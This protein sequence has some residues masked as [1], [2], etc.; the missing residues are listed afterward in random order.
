MIPYF[1]YRPALAEMRAELDD[2]FAR[3]LDSGRLILGAEVESFESE[4]GEFIG[5]PHA[6]G[7]GSGTDALILALRALGVGSGHEVITVANAGAPPVAAI[8]AVGARPRFVDVRP[9]TLL[10][11]CS[12]VDNAITDATRALLPVHLYGQAVELD[13][14]LRIS[15]EH[16]LPVIE[17]CAQAHGATVRGVP[18]GGFGDVGCFSFY[19][20]KNLGAFGDGG[21]AVTRDAALAERIR[22][23]RMYGF[24]GDL[25]AHREGLN[26]RLDEL[27][28][29]LLRVRLRHLPAANRRR[30]EIAAAYL[31]GLSDS[32]LRLPVVAAENGHVF[33]LFVV[34]GRD[35]ARLA[36]ALSD[37]EIGYG[38]HYPQPAHL[39]EAYLPLGGKAGDLPVSEEASRAVLSLPIYP[40]LA[41]SDVARVVQV[42]RAACEDA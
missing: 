16:G 10:M 21:M 15:R 35:R 20:T 28:A 30:C 14:L 11:D 26:S 34:R 8:R 25:I 9:D 31:N 41:D 13:P 18:V 32:A 42:V 3:V 36:G 29:A 27:Q 7:V 38:V 4:F 17:D 23:L 6:V 22:E 40:G 19:P 33:H 1:D 24:R 5:V 37:A 39:M 2:A 12:Q